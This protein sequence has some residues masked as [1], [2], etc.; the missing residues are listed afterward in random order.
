VAEIVPVVVTAAPD[1]VDPLPSAQV[2]APVPEPPEVVPEMV[3]PKVADPELA[4]KA[5]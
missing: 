2:T 5:A 1:A 4:V 3:F